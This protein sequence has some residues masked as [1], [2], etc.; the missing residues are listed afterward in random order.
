MEDNYADD[1]FSD[2]DFDV[3]AELQRTQKI[4]TQHEENMQH[5]QLQGRIAVLETQLQELDRRR[6][7]KE[8]DIKQQYEMRLQ[9][10]EAELEAKGK[11]LK[12]REAQLEF[13]KDRD[14]FKAI[15][16]KLNKRRKI[17]PQTGNSND[18][19][20]IT[21]PSSYN[22]SMHT[23]IRDTPTM[24]STPPRP[25]DKIIVLN[26]TAWYEDERS[27]FTELIS[28]YVIPGT[29]KSVLEFLANITSK[30]DYEYRGFKMVHERDDFKSIILKF[31]IEFDNKHRIDFLISNFI[32]FIFDY[33]QQCLLP[34]NYCLL[35]VIFLL[36]LMNFSLTYRPKAI[37]EQV[38]QSTTRTITS[39]LNM[40]PDLISSTINYLST[41]EDS[42][43][44]LAYIQSS[45]DE[46]MDYS[47]LEKPIHI[48]LLEI[49]CAVYSIDILETLA[50]ITSFQS[51]VI[52]NSKAS[53]YFWTNIQPKLFYS[54]LQ[55]FTTSYFVS[56]GI[57]ILISSTFEN[58]NFA[59][60]FKK[61]R[62][63]EMINSKIVT[64]LLSLFDESNN[65]N[66]F[67]TS[68]LNRAIGSN[69]FTKM[70]ELIAPLPDNHSSKPRTHPLEDY[71]EILSA[72]EDDQY[73][74]L[75]F[76]LQLI[77]LFEILLSSN[78]TINFDEVQY[79][80]FIKLCKLIDDEQTAIFKDPRSRNIDMMVSIITKSVLIIKFLITDLNFQL[81]IQ[82][83]EGKLFIISLLRI[84]SDNMKEI[85]LNFIKN[86]RSKG[87][88]GEIFNQLLEDKI[89]DKF[90]D[91]TDEMKMEIE[92]ES[93]NGIE[94][95][96]SN[97]L[98][99]TSKDLLIDLL[100]EL[101]ADKLT[102]SI[103]FD[104]A[105]F[106]ELDA[107]GDIELLD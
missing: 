78:E 25:K 55:P 72:Y 30:F 35:Q 60:T 90:G 20:I 44:V 50:N 68:G 3:A 33:I 100:G 85:S 98:I 62:N 51:E 102:S 95:D 70:I 48:K 28:N 57:R 107:D 27:N 54:L 91:L 21:A 19:Q 84:S 104:L 89:L 7:Q 10:K 67:N 83:L 75:D 36:P 24:N 6:L 5:Y 16:E 105:N 41:P 29:S 31:L 96:Y 22:N 106:D 77:N 15:D 46:I 53:N 66:T 2:D 56:T 87:F 1:S 82:T 58:S 61:D 69:S 80:L 34:E 4:R 45:K 43:T 73:I 13:W 63:G 74:K 32:D 38:I 37:S 94:F 79:Q 49:F 8:E 42:N 52:P 101:D 12:D 93:I 9:S 65:K 88:K 103:N 97:D 64:H 17:Q 18:T 81:P 23:T 39:I 47:F 11:E 99:E 86:V 71:Q 92:M 14:E 76:K 40:F 59:Y 26:Q